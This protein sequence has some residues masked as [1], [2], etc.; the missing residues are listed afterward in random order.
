M[1][2]LTESPFPDDA[3]ISE[4]QRNLAQ[5]L[6]RFEQVASQG[7]EALPQT[8]L[9]YR[10]E[11]RPAATALNQLL[12]DASKRVASWGQRLLSNAAD[13]FATTG[14]QLAGDAFFYTGVQQMN[15]ISHALEERVIADRLQAEVHAGFQRFSLIVPQL[16][17]YRTLLERADHVCVYGLD[18]RKPDSPLLAMKHPRLIYLP[19]EPAMQTGLERFW[20]VV[21]I[22]ARLQTA[23]VAQQTGGDA[24][25]R[26]QA[27]RTYSGLWTFDPALVQQIGTILR[28][29]A[30]KLYYKQA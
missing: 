1:N 26:K 10:A 20:F 6:L 16:G 22:S 7:M 24:W 9:N 14:N 5:G 3:Q 11:Y 28:T 8:P 13:D 4:S 18:D 19:I 17:R 2:D 27:Q 29:A 30:I 12:S 23:L 15:L 25:A 21:V